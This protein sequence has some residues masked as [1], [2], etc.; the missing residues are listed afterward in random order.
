MN[1]NVYSNPGKAREISSVAPFSPL[2]PSSRGEIFRRGACLAPPGSSQEH[3]RP[4]I[5][6]LIDVTTASPPPSPTYQATRDNRSRK[7]RAEDS[8]ATEVGTRSDA[9]PRARAVRRVWTRVC[10]AVTPVT[11]RPPRPC[12]HAALAVDEASP[13]A[14]GR[15]RELRKGASR[16]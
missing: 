8:T 9:S 14:R 7:H 10:A 1:V 12:D 2:L 16:S 3:A 13:G 6:T 15:A 11:P 5:Q 4:S